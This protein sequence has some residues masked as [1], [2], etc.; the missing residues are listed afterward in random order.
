MADRAVQWHKVGMFALALGAAIVVCKRKR[1][2][3]EERYGPLGQ[4]RRAGTAEALVDYATTT[5]K[6]GEVRG[7]LE[8][9]HDEARAALRAAGVPRPD[10]LDRVLGK[11]LEDVEHR[12]RYTV[13]DSTLDR[14][15]FEAVAPLLAAPGAE[16]APVEERVGKRLDCGR[17]MSEAFAAITGNDVIEFDED[18]VDS[19]VEVRVTMTIGASGTGYVESHRKRVFPGIALAGELDLVVGGT[20]I[21]KLAFDVKPAEKLAYTTWQLSGMTKDGRDGDIAYA[22]IDSVCA[23]LGNA[24]ATH[25]TG[26]QPAAAPVPGRDDA[27]A[28][29]EQ[30]GEADDCLAA[31]TALRDDD[32]E[33]AIAMFDKGCD[34][35]GLASGESCVEGAAL[36]LATAPAQAPAAPTAGPWAEQRAREARTKAWVMLKRGCDD[37]HPPACLAYAEL[38][39]TRDATPPRQ[40]K[41]D[42]ALEVLVRACDLGADVACDRAAALVAAPGFGGTP[43]GSAAAALA[44]RGCADA[45]CPDA[46]RYA[47]LGARDK[48][49]FGVALGKD[50]IFDVRWGQ[51]YR[52]EPG[53][54]VVWVASTADAAAVAGRVHG[55]KTRVYG[56]GSDELPYGVRPPDDARTVWAVIP[57]EP[58]D[59]TG[60]GVSACGECTTGE[61]NEPLYSMGCTCLPLKGR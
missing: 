8:A 27:I 9:L 57:E 20:S 26:W 59:I 4:A 56:L 30:R 18:A 44:T 34:S 25:L 10:G 6:Q 45:T 14:A 1:D 29:C 61:A 22:M 17:G 15:S 2:A 32:R 37:Y 39:L 31:G 53:H 7:N 60:S 21:D 49:V 54:V 11:L 3:N 23:Q 51:W 46:A 33:R 24:L 41:V 55:P 58:R 47:K 5:G 42:E 35:G 48:A 36:I 43:L 38:E 40:Y 12:V 50:R 19:S 13:I 28:A 52:H 16:L